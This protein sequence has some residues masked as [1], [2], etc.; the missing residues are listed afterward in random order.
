M[1]EKKVNIKQLIGPTVS[2]LTDTKPSWTSSGVQCRGDRDRGDLQ[3]AL[4]SSTLTP[5][6]I[7]RVL[8]NTSQAH[9]VRTGQG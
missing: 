5:A 1:D 7:E 9:P 4:D 3:H 6:P 2:V 8:K